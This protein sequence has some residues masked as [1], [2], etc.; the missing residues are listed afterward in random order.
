MLLGLLGRK[1]GGGLGSTL[2]LALIIVVLSVLLGVGISRYGERIPVLGTLFA[3][4]TP[5]TTTSPVII[6]GIQRL[7]QLATVRWTESV[8]V[9]NESTQKPLGKLL[10]GEKI[11]LVAAG[12]VE[13][14]VNLSYLGPEEVEVDG[15]KVTIELPEPE[16]LSSSLDEKRTGVYDRDQGLLRL[17]PDDA[18]VDNA[19]QQ[20]EQEI[21]ST[22]WENGILDYAEQNAEESIRAFATTLGFEEVEFTS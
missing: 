8:V 22:A 12:E 20:A 21:V 2:V 1:Q 7:D 17:R 10:T 4:G 19:R 3:D 16:I 6:E 15:G 18:L 5:N 9:T 13:A 14:G 11:V